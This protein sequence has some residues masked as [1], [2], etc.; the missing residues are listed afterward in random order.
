MSNEIIK[1]TGIDTFKIKDNKI[2]KEVLE[3]LIESVKNEDEWENDWEDYDIENMVL[4]YNKRDLDD[5]WIIFKDDGDLANYNSNN[6]R[7]TECNDYDSTYYFIKDGSFAAENY[8][9]NLKN[10]DCIVYEVVGE[11]EK[12]KVEDDN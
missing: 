10:E 9:Q 12:M 7:Y 5:E 3:F 8:Y 1:R 6:A 11:L 4:L 2:T